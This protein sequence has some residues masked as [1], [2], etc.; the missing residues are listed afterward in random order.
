MKLMI[1]GGSRGTGAELATLAQNAGHEVTTISRSG[2]T[3]QA[4]AKDPASIAP[5]IS[6]ADAVVITVGGAKGVSRNR[7]QVTKAVVQ[8]MTEQGVRRL[9]VQSSLGAGDSRKHLPKAIA[10][11]TQAVLARA[12]ADHN[13]QE[14]IVRGSELEWTIIRPSGLSSKEAHGTWQTAEESQPASLG[15]S[16][17]R[18]DVAAYML[19]ILTDESTF[20]RAI[21][22]AGG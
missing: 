11:F 17:P 10:L 22:I 16:I 8:A 1:I 15:A 18:Q 13:D 6:G 21:S 20:G 4:D 2:G 7:A 9:I 3:V 5:I 14:G 12:L 19:S